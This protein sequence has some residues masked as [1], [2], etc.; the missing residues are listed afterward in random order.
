LVAI[1]SPEW[2]LLG[3][4]TLWRERTL[5]PASAM[6]K[7]FSN[8]FN[9]GVTA[10]DADAHGNC[11]YAHRQNML[12]PAFKVMG[13]GR[14]NNN[15]S[16]YGWYWTIDFGGVV[17]QSDG[18]RDRSSAQAPPAGGA[19]TYHGGPV[20]LGTTHIYYIWYGE[21]VARSQRQCDIDEFCEQYWRFTILQ[22]QYDLPRL[23]EHQSLQFSD[24]RR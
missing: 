24:I 15:K 20:M 22:H 8:I 11:T 17:D 4:R 23:N 1:H 21:L 18:R 16:T 6:L 19:I 3:I 14:A 13:I 12:N 7:T 9:Q 5:L 2:R 10:C